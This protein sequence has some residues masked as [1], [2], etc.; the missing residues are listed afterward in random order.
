[1]PKIPVAA[2]DEER[3]ALAA[4]VTC[5]QERFELTNQRLAD[6]EARP[7]NDEI[8][9]TTWTRRASLPQIMPWLQKRLFRSTT[10]TKMTKVKFALSRLVH[11]L[12]ASI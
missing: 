4:E 9:S 2:F 1:M 12:A 7:V 5:L 8:E 11:G 10:T 3:E 6:A